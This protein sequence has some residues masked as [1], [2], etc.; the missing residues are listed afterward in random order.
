M[1]S[2]CNRGSVLEVNL[3]PSVGREYMKPRPC[4]VVQSDLLN[5]YS[6]VT[7][8]APITGLKNVPKRGP[9]YVLIPKG[10]GGLPKDSL[11]VCHQL[12]TVDESRFG[13]IYGQ[14]KPET[15]R[16]VAAALKIVLDLQEDSLQTAPH[17]LKPS[18]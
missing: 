2:K 7:I 18:S 11:A 10:D 13:K 3:D 12:R 14:V 17:A 16:Q 5:K 4:L 1:P 6:Q 8:V 15:M 9:T